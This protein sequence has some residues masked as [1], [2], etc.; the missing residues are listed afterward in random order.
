VKPFLIGIAG[1]SGSGKTELAYR[2]QAKLDGAVLLSLDSY[3]LCQGHLPHADRCLRNF[4]DPAMLD[5]ELIRRQVFALSQGETIGHPVY[6]FEDHIRLLETVPVHPSPYLIVEGIFALHDEGLRQLFDSSFYVTAPDSV[7]LAR[8]M[9]RDVLYR[10]RTEQSVIDQYDATVRPMAELYV[11][12]T[13]HFADL[14]VSG[15]QPIDASVASAL[16]FV[17]AGT[18]AIAAVAAIAAIAAIVAVSSAQRVSNEIT[19]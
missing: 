13:E 18:V 17:A 3:Y 12:P 11:L 7:C 1:P 14:S 15:T 6:S 19:A 9:E 4:D 5:W 10:G 8:R 2:L 16:E